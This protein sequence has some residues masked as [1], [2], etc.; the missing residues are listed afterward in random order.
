VHGS[1]SDDWL[2]IGDCADLVPPK[3]SRWPGSLSASK[4][5][6]APF[7]LYREFWDSTEHPH[8]DTVNPTEVAVA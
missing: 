3:R 5:T 4:W 6:F 1:R 8:T 2:N 7:W